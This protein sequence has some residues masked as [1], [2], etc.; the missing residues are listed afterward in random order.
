MSRDVDRCDDCEEYVPIENLELIRAGGSWHGLRRV[1][2]SCLADRERRN[3]PPAE[4]PTE[5][6]EDFDELLSRTR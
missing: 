5:W 3:P 1:C 2:A 6:I 4:I